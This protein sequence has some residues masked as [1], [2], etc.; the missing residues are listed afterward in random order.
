MFVWVGSVA[1]STM[2]DASMANPPHHRAMGFPMMGMERTN[3]CEFNTVNLARQVRTGNVKNIIIVI[4]AVTI[5]VA[6]F[7]GNDESP[8]SDASSANKLQTAQTIPNEC[9]EEAQITGKQYNVIGSE[10]YVRKGPGTNFDKIVNQKATNFFKTTHYISIDDST[11]VFE[12]CSKGGW[13]WIRVLQPDWLQNSHR[14]WV[15]SKFLDKGQDIGSDPYARKI[16]SYALM[17]YDAKNY[18]KTT[19]QYG[20]RL[21]EIEQLRRK[22]AEMA[23]DSG[24]CDFVEIVELSDSKSTLKHLHFWVDCRNG[25][26]I[27][28]DEFEIKAKGSVLTQKEKAWD[29]A[30]AKNACRDAIK[31]RAMIPS[32]LDIHDIIGTSFYEAPLTHNVVITM[33]FDA[34]NAF[35]IDI[36][37]TAKCYFQPGEVG[38]IELNK[39]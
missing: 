28:L 15:L 2:L 14:G 4:I 9:K 16:S 26:R 32:E 5:A 23:V 33:D 6:L 7:S 35:G 25:E 3:Q 22:A 24:K 10:I 31:A 20:T 19:K 8:Q 12:E 1:S 29:E 34:K 27:R 18:P 13:S 17:P 21:E 38:V 37:Y 30:S 36:P 11:V 39:R